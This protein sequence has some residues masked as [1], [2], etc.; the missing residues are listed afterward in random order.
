MKQKGTQQKLLW[1]ALCGFVNGLF[2]SGGG[3]VAVM[4]LRRFAADEQRVH[5]TATLTI[6]I[7]SVVSFFLYLKSG[8]VDIGEGMRFLPGGMIGA[9]LGSKLLKGSGSAVLRRFFGGVIAASGVV[10]LFR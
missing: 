9:L 3:V 5:A 2:G 10:M 6:F 8:S 1:G 4:A 7:M